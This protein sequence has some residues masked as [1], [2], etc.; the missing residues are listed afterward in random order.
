[1]K[2]PDK[3][4]FE[5]E[6][7]EAKNNWEL[8]KLYVDLASAKGKALTPVEKKFLRG[9]LCAF[10][11]AE[12]AKTVYNSNSSS[13]VRVYLSNG[14]YKYIEEM[15]CKQ[16]GYSVKVK[17]WSR[18]TPLLEK[19]GYKK[20][21][22]SINGVNR[23][24]GVTAYQ[25]KEK[26]DF[27][28]IESAA[29]LDWGEAIDVSSF[30]GRDEDLAQVK[31]WIIQDN[32]RLV[33]LLG[34]G[35]IGKTALSVKLAEQISQE[36]FDYVIW[37]SLHLSPS[38]DVLL[39]QI[40]KI[41]SPDY[42]GM[43][44]DNIDNNISLLIDCLRSSRC[45]IVL[46]ALDSI[47]CN[48]CLGEVDYSNLT[49]D[50][51]DEINSIG[52]NTAQICYRP[53]YEGYGELIRRL[54]DSQHQSSLLL[55]S[56]EKPQEIVVLA[57]QTL[58]V[59]CLKLDGLNYKESGEILKSKGF[60]KIKNDE[61]KLLIDCYAGNPLFLKLVSTAIQELFN[62]N[63]YEF[64]EQGTVVFGDIRA[65]LD[66]QFNRLSTLEKQ[67][68]YWLALN[69]DFVSVRKLQKEILLRVSQRVILEAIDS[70]QRRSLI[71]RKESNFYIAPVIIE[72]IGER[73]I[74]ENFRLMRHNSGLSLINQTI[75]E[76]QLKNYIREEALKSRYLK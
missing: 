76:T 27:V 70:L 20:N 75:F 35:G 14:L 26:A 5:E 12:I 61:I 18:V 73:L 50:I 51:L 55:T 49:T 2:A 44:S 68:M 63:I 74:E 15:L 39:K 59:R 8:E 65:V 52:Y 38:V 45:L 22:I 31:E 36:N 58:P 1:M 10:S 60:K 62:G 17:N 30:C 33:L 54:G 11:P 40:L 25:G 71:I 4:N 32:C 72:Y 21:R 48:G 37:R 23:I 28:S 66:Q 69:Q 47:L 41:I 24:N 57:G 16:M 19:A 67:I 43:I 34:I 13:T 7:I 3:N 53:G 56:R 42:E 6:F 64:L 29:K 9:L 46:D